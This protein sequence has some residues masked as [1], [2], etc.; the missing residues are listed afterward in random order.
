M[1][2]GLRRKF[3]SGTHLAIMVAMLCVIT[4]T[5]LLTNLLPVRVVS[6]YQSRFF[7]S[8]FILVEMRNYFLHP[9]FPLD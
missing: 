8:L 3:A 2:I 4:A 9:N 5:F 7:S 6:S 1:A